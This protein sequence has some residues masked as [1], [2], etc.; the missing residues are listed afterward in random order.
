M[1]PPIC[2]VCDKDFRDESDGGDTVSFLL[3]EED[4]EDNKKL[5][6]EGMAGH[7][8][9]MEWF[10]DEHLPVA[11]KYQHLTLAEALP[12]IKEEI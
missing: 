5:D 10:C 9:G 8:A 3:T 7:P 1:R 4:K 11:K 2:A 6:E 12:K